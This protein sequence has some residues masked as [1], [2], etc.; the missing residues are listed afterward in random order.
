MLSFTLAPDVSDSD[1]E[2]SKFKSPDRAT[3]PPNDSRLSPAL[4]EETFDMMKDSEFSSSVP[5]A[6]TC[7]DAPSRFTIPL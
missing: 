1:M 7:L 4:A 6:A 3:E 2:I 5:V